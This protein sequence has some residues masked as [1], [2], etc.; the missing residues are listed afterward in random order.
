M[1]NVRKKLASLSAEDREH[2]VLDSPRLLK[3]AGDI[4]K[5]VKNLTNFDFVNAKCRLT[6][7]QLLI[8]DFAYLESLPASESD[9]LIQSWLKD[10]DELKEVLRQLANI[11][12]EDPK[13]GD[14]PY[15]ELAGQLSARINTSNS[16]LL[17][18]LCKQ[19]IDSQEEERKTWLCAR[20]PFLQATDTS[21]FKTFTGHTSY[22]RCLTTSAD[23]KLVIAGDI[24][25]KIKVW[26]FDT[27]QCLA[28]LVGHESDITDLIISPKG[29]LVSAS[30]DGS[31][32][33]WSIKDGSLEQ[34]LRAPDATPTRTFHGEPPR[35]SVYGLAF[36]PDGY[37]LATYNDY[38]IRRWNIATGEYVDAPFNRLRT[39]STVCCSASGM[40]LVSS[41]DHVFQLDLHS[42][43]SII[44]S[45]QISGVHSIALATN[46]QFYV[47]NA[48]R[49][50]MLIDTRI[51]D[52]SEFEESERRFFKGHTAVVN[53]V[54]LSS[55]MKT[56]VS[57][58]NRGEVFVWDAETGKLKFAFDGHSQPVY[59]VTISPD[60]RYAI[61]AGMDALIKVWRLDRIP[62]Q[63]APF[64]PLVRK[65]SINTLATTPDG[66]YVVAGG[67]EGMLQMW[68]IPKM[69]LIYAFESNESHVNCLAITSDSRYLFSGSDDFKILCWDL[70]NRES[71]HRFGRCVNAV[72][73]LVMTHGDRLL[74]ASYAGEGLSSPT[75]SA[76]PHSTVRWWDVERFKQPIEDKAD[77]N[78]DYRS[79][80]DSVDE[81]RG[82]V[83]KLVRLIC[84]LI[85]RI[86]HRFFRKATRPRSQLKHAFYN[87]EKL[88]SF[89]EYI[90][91]QIG[92]PERIAVSLN[93]E[94]L[95]VSSFEIGGEDPKVVLLAKNRLNVLTYGSFN[96]VLR[97][98]CV[99]TTDS[100]YLITG[101]SGGDELRVIDLSSGSEV[102]SLISSD[103]KGER[104]QS[105]PRAVDA[106]DVQNLA[107]S[108]NGQ[109]IAAASFH[110]YIR[111][112]HWPSRKLVATYTAEASMLCCDFTVDSKQLIVGDRSGNLHFLHIKNPV[113]TKRESA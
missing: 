96:F 54:T 49:D 6:G 29:S 11:L 80:I 91:H 55:D 75:G 34:K 107:I 100:R 24:N 30:I 57:G 110:K 28:T 14:D 5:L 67:D 32:C 104:W 102:E 109:F 71:V 53:S 78:I 43:R 25:E 18:E 74:S 111:L 90:S 33:V 86:R 65:P 85:S 20:K 94:W 99:F 83:A 60:G 92:S 88:V 103:Q 68:D 10:L 38:T 48:G 13:R 73:S 8:S 69:K 81:N 70:K 27:S 22:I 95:A 7:V 84:K 87:G 72:Q 19:A 108:P 45:E 16:P 93:G 52:S 105:E 47:C 41:E 98:P 58:S 40:M 42:T 15:A 77:E 64:N 101:S 79:N 31:I 39:G 12:I 76:W 112:W 2:V 59:A 89:T 97:A 3:K 4:T 46:E 21:P 50:L 35:T 23:G 37:L 61:S 1:G 9:E 106:R 26:N 82:L 63:I 56:I 44:S 66:R 113:H 36:D 17:E 51:S 62:Q